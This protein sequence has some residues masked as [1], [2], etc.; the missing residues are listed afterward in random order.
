MY[1]ALAGDE[2]R[3]VPLKERDRFPPSAL[4]RIP[5][6]LAPDAANHLRGLVS[7]VPSLEITAGN[8]TTRPDVTVSE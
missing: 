2:L 5:H 1:W 6:R 4:T 3:I 7:G 8:T